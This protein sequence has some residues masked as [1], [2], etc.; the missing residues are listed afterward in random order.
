METAIV[1][2]DGTVI[3]PKAICEALGLH[4]GAVVEFL[5]VGYQLEIRVQGAR[6]P[7]YPHAPISGYGMIK[8]NRPSV[9]VDFD[10]AELLK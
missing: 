2:S 9:P 7:A 3:V 8:S 5:V 6:P 1:N 10:P 4:A